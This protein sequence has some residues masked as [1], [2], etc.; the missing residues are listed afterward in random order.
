M[1]LAF[2]ALGYTAPFDAELKRITGAVCAAAETMSAR[3]GYGGKAAPAPASKVTGVHR[4]R[5]RRGLECRCAIP[6]EIRRMG[7]LRRA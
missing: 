3:L 4:R 1:A 6:A 5:S 7:F 2:V